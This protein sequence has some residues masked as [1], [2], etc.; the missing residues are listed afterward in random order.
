MD[1]KIHQENDRTATL[2]RLEKW[3]K[4]NIGFKVVASQYHSQITGSK[5]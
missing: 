2:K 4:L 3:V 1:E 5:C